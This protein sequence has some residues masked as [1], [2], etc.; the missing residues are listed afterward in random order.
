MAEDQ[1]QEAEK[2]TFESDSLD[3]P[4]DTLPVAYLPSTICA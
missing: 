2:A 1:F 3:Y 4:A